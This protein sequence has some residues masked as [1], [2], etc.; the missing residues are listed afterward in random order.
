M[1]GMAPPVKAAKPYRIAYAAVQMNDDFYLGIAWGVVDEARRAGALL[2]RT[3]NAGGYGKSAEQIG[4]LEELKALGVDAILIVGATF[5][6]YDKVVERLAAS[7]IRVISVASPISAPETTLGVLQDETALGARIANFICQKAP[8]STVLTLPGPAGTEWNKVRFDG[9][10]AR[11]QQCG[12]TL[13]GNTFRGNISI[14][15]GQQQVQDGLLKYPDV[16]YV[17][18]VS[19]ALAVGAAQQIRRS[20]AKPKVVTGTVNE[21]TIGLVKEGIIE[22]VASEPSVLFGRAALQYAVRSLNG[23]PLLGAKSGVLPYPVVFVPNTEI[24]RDNIDHYDM[25]LADL[26]PKG[27]QPP[28]FGH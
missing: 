2:V 10:K 19:G 16:A 24:T 25:Y 15:D 21:R 20:G 26:P 18:A 4:Q 13:V 12:L 7:G 28:A 3:T 6:G 22:M 1:L 17:Y 8:K 14:E 11:A 9:F 27:W 23:D 5:N